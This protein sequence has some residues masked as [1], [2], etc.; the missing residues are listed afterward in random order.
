MASSRRRYDL[1]DA[2]TNVPYVPFTAEVWI[3]FGMGWGSIWVQMDPQPN[4][5]NPS[6]REALKTVLFGSID[7]NVGVGWLG[8]P[9]HL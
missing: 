1:P 3:G 5:L 4:G 9:K 8:G 2:Y 6:L 7:P